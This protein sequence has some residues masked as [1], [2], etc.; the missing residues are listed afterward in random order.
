M[1]YSTTVL[2]HFARPRNAGQLPSANA[3]GQAGIPGQGN[4]MVFFLRIEDDRVAEASFETF[5]CPGS[6]ASGSILTE[7]VTG[8]SLEE[9][10]S[11][12]PQVILTA[13]GGLPPGRE[14]CADLAVAALRKALDD[15]ASP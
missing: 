7:L 3:Q 9:A 13:L 1:Q 8:S 6:I 4:Y 15:Y 12:D 14:Q 2:E 10:L 5:G 11:M